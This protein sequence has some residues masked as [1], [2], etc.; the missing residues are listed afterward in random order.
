M[1]FLAPL[2]SML[3]VAAAAD[4][5]GIYCGDGVSLSP[6]VRRKIDLMCANL[7]CSPNH[8]QCSDGLLIVGGTSELSSCQ[9][10]GEIWSYCYLIV[11]SGDFTATL[12]TEESG[13]TDGVTL[14]NGDCTG[15]GNWV[16]FEV[17]SS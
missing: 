17:V 16:S 5:W 13:C 14:S 8:L 10:L 3:S 15:A 12:F 7:T 4:S 9:T 2:V 6:T 1:K 11:D